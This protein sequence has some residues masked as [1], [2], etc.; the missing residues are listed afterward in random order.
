M[1][2]GILS[3]CQCA[4]CA[5]DDLAC[6]L[7]EPPQVSLAAYAVAA[8]SCCCAGTAAQCVSCA[9]SNTR[10]SMSHCHVH[11]WSKLGQSWSNFL[12]RTAIIWLVL[13]TPCHTRQPASSSRN[14][15]VTRA[16]LLNTS[17]SIVSTAAIALTGLVGAEVTSGLLGDSCC[18]VITSPLLLVVSAE[19]A[20]L[21]ASCKLWL[22]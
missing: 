4:Y 22:C 11:S 6:R 2:A 1:A 19:A 21:V 7:L 20:L 12:Q 3:R 8:H 10:C 18:A 15:L 14:A 17:S 5:V 9:G 16:A 13:V